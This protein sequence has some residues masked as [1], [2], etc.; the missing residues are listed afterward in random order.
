MTPPKNNRTSFS[1]RF[2]NTT[3][4]ET[5][6]WHVLDWILWE[7]DEYDESLITN[8]LVVWNI[9]PYIGNFIIPTDF[10]FFQRGRYT[11]NQQIVGATLQS[12]KAYPYVLRIVRRP[13][14]SPFALTTWRSPLVMGKRLVFHQQK[15]WD[16]AVIGICW[17]ILWLNQQESRNIQNSPRKCEI[18]VWFIHGKL[19]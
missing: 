14:S 6:R 13:P 7:W 16:I 2:K 18:Y 10:L 11:T 9:F 8:W 4:N 5:Q 19:G 15:C 1:F 3:R 12:P 17:R